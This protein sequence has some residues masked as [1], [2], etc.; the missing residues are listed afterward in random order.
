[1]QL[2]A[3]THEDQKTVPGETLGAALEAIA[4][5]LA[6]H[7]AEA[8]KPWIV[9]QIRAPAQVSDTEE[10]PA[11]LKVEEAA[12]ILRIGR[13]TAYELVRTHRIPSINLGRRIV[14]PTAKLFE[15]LNDGQD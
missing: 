13:D 9:S 15:F 8:L 5:V 7:V 4:C 14:I 12:K 6:H 11:L 10:L 3:E 1:M 2:R